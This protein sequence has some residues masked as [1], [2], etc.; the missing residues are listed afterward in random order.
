M[1]SLLVEK[2]D[3]SAPQTLLSILPT[4]ACSRER[5]ESISCLK[6]KPHFAKEFNRCSM[7]VGFVGHVPASN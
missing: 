5:G 3:Y 7:F 6:S 1:A 2:M 4:R